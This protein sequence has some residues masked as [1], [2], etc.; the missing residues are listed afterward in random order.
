MWHQ[1]GALWTMKQLFLKVGIA[2][3][4]VNGGDHITRVSGIRCKYYQHLQEQDGFNREST[5]SIK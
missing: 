1:E 3:K 2:R 5:A 4:Q